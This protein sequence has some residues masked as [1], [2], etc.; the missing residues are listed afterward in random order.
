MLSLM[1]ASSI[2]ERTTRAQHLR[3]AIDLV[4]EASTQ[5][6]RLR[7]MDWPLWHLLRGESISLAQGLASARHGKTEVKVMCHQN[8]T[9]SMVHHNT[10]SYS[11]TSI[12][13]R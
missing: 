12:S 4:H 6:P 10:Y 13:D 11:V 2:I 3:A 9:T 7:D 8:L 1:T 5:R